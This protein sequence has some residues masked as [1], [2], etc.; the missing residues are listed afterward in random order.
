MVDIEKRIE[1]YLKTGR[2]EGMYYYSVCV[3]AVSKEQQ[4]ANNCSKAMAL[5]VSDKKPPQVK[6]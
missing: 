5:R 3:D 6:K 2:D 4:A 1:M